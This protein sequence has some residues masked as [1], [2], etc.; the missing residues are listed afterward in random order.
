M[1][2]SKTIGHNKDPVQL[3]P[4]TG[5][6]PLKNFD[7]NYC[8]SA[9][10]SFN[11][12]GHLENCPGVGAEVLPILNPY[13]PKSTDWQL[14]DCGTGTPYPTICADDYYPKLDGGSLKQATLCPPGACDDDPPQG[15]APIDGALCQEANQTNC[16][17]TVI[18]DYTTSFN[19]AQFNFSAIWLRTRW[20]LVSNSF[21]S[22][23]QNA[24]LTFVS[25]GDYTHSSAIKGLWELAL[26]T[27]FVGQT[28]KDSDAPFASSTLN[29]L[30]CDNP[31]LQQ[32]L[33]CISK[34]NSFA[35]GKHTAFAVSQ[36]MFNIYDGPADQDLNA[37]LDIKKYDLGTDSARSVYKKVAGI[38]KAVQADPKAIPVGACYIQ[39]AAIGWKQ[40]NGFYY[41]PTFHSRNLF[42]DNVDIRHY[43]I[44]P[45]FE[46]NTY[47]T[48]KT[49]VGIRY[50]APPAHI[51]FEKMFEGFSANDRQT[52]LTD[53]DGSLTGYANTTSINTDD[54]FR[55]PIEGIECQSDGAVPEGGT[56][57]TS[58]Y[59]MVTTVVYPDAA[60]SPSPAGSWGAVCWKDPNPAQPPGEG[61]DKKIGAHPDPNWDSA[62]TDHSCFGVP[63]YR[64]YQ[65]GSEKS[66]KK[67]PEFIRMA[68]FNIC[69]RQTMTV[70]H[71]LYYVDLTASAKTQNAWAGENSKKNIFVAG[72]TY[73]FF[74]VYAKK[75]TEQTYK[76]YVG[77]EFD[78]TTGVK[79]IRANIVNAPFKISPG[80]G[81]Q[82]TLTT[83]YDASTYILTVRL[84]L[85][86][87]GDNFISAAKDLCVPKTFCDWD[88]GKC[89]GNNKA[90]FGNNKA[91]F[92][93][94][95]PDERNIAC[96][97]AGKDIDCP[98]GGCVGFSV[99]LPNKFQANDLTTMPSA[100]AQ[101][102]PKDAKW[103]VPLKNADPPELAGA[104]SQAL[105]KT[106]FP[107]CP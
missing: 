97:Y 45:Q 81:D 99:T 68:G 2:R 98:T 93:N 91:G 19:W 49:Q 76:M 51:N 17:P 7:G 31:D 75:D 28:Q 40:P 37:Y 9:M 77:P 84:N 29:W 106:D 96:S 25:G 89:V 90:G 107:T 103:N 23:V 82:T 24:G 35:L 18:N 63:L 88:G 92:G 74:L 13:A 5:T 10:T 85:S 8:T 14:P 79:L 6:S 1:P 30:T 39:N 72:N 78:K 38:P 71:G 50:C 101:C 95:T 26:K 104:C 61:P 70:N 73:H 34:N 66:Q 94:L 83:E 65:T 80:T 64:L 100:L 36:H 58:P 102:F 47:K 15:V 21:I 67:V 11:T 48:D 59:P 20:H 22:D 3:C 43:V 33:Y 41:P 32:Q 62:C 57:R 60:Q 12:V 56:A 42:F 53:D 27:V 105:M 86:A 54:F 55:A 16:L 44:V 4:R 69:Q 46:T 52:I 87:F